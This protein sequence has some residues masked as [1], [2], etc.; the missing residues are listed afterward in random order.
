[1][2]PGS[3]PERGGVDGS[4]SSERLQ[5][6][7]GSD[8]AQL[9]SFAELLPEIVLTVSPTGE[10]AFA[11]S[12]VEET[13]GIEPD[14]F[15]GRSLNL[16]FAKER[17]E[18]IEEL[19]SR[20]DGDE[21]GETIQFAT[22]SGASQPVT[23]SVT[24]LEEGDGYV[25]LASTRAQIQRELEQY[26]QLVEAVGDPMYVLD[27][28]GY[29]QRVNDAMVEYTGYDRTEL[30]GRAIGE[31]IPSREYGR[32]TN[33]LA[34][35][36]A[37]SVQ[38]SET[39][40]TKLVTRDG[41]VIL[42]E[43]N[44]TTLFDDGTVTGSVGVLRDIR[45]RKRR[46]RDLEMLKEV[47]ARV[48]RHNVRNELSV[49][50]GNAEFAHR[51]VGDEL[52][53]YT[54]KI[55]ERTE[56]LL[57]HTEKARLAEEVI[58]TE[59]QYETD[60]AI[61]VEEVKAT[62]SDEYPDATI[63]VDVPDDTS[64]TAIAELDSAIEELL[65]NAIDHAPEDSDAYVT[66]WAD[67]TDEFLTLFVEDESGGLADHEIDVLR[68]GAES[69][70]EHGSGVGLWL[71]RWI[72]EYSNAD[73]IAHRTDNGTLMGIRFPHASN[74]ASES[75]DID[76]SPFTRAPSHVQ[77]IEPERF[78]G[79]IVVGRMDEL[80]ELEDTYAAL[81]RKGGHAVLVTG[82]AGVGKS[83]LVE[84]FRERLVGGEEPPL[85]A[86][87]ASESDVTQPYHVFREA[88]AGL[89]VDTGLQS[90]LEDVADFDAEDPEAVQ[91][92]KQ[93][94]FADMA[95]ELRE[96]ALD[97]S[98]VLVLEDLQWADRGSLDLF[99]YL[100]E[101]V[102]RWAPP[103][104]FVGTCRIDDVGVSHPVLDIA[105]QTAE[106]GRG[107][108]I[109]LDAFEH[110]DVA[111]F[112]EFML[113]I[114]EVPPEFVETVHDHTGGTP[115]FVSELGRHLA[116]TL[117]PSPSA[118]D[119][120]TSLD[121]I[122]APETV[123]SAL[124]ERLD[125]LS[126]DVR[127]VL[128]VGAIVGDTIPFEVLREVS[129][130]PEADLI[131]HVE[132]L[133]GRHIWE[134]DANTLQFV[135]GVLR[136]NIL[137]TVDDDE[138]VALHGE[139]ARTIETLYADSLEEQYGR[140][141]IHYDEA[142]EPETAL[143]YYRRAGDRAA[144]TYAHRTALDHY[145]RALELAEA[146]DSDAYLTVAQRLAEIN[147][148]IGEYDR[149]THFVE[150]VRES[151]DDEAIEQRQQVAHLGA[152]IA[153]ERGEYD[154]AEETVREG[155][156]LDD[157]PSEVRCRL[158]EVLVKLQQEQ[159]QYETAHE[160]AT[161]IRDIATTIG[162]PQLRAVAIHYLGVLGWRLGNV[163]SARKYSTECL[164]IAEE[165]GD[166]K[167]AADSHHFLGVIAWAEGEYDQA[168]EHYEDSLEIKRDISDRHGEAKTLN[169][170][171]LALQDQGEYKQA[172]EYYEQCLDTYRD[173]G[174]RH[175]MA[176]TFN[177]LGIVARIQSE[178]GQAREYYERCL[179]IERAVGGRHGEAKA[180]NNLGE[181]DRQQGVFEQAQTRLTESLEIKREVSDQRDEAETLTHLGYVSYH[182]GEY[183]QAREYFEESLDIATEVGT[184][185]EVIATLCGL[186]AVCRV[187]DDDEGRQF[188]EDGLGHVG[189]GGDPLTV[190]Q[191][192]LEAARWEL[193][194]G[195]LDAAR[196]YTTQ[197]HE[198]FADLGATHWVARSH[199]RHAE[200]AAAA[201][202]PEDAQTYWQAAL[203]AFHTVGAPHD[204][205]AT[206]E[207]LSESYR[208]SGDE[209]RA[210]E[211]REYAKTVC[212]DA[213]DEVTQQHADWVDDHT[214]DE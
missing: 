11:N 136:E 98:V 76:D 57:D 24:R 211:L 118:S 207:Q 21:A 188:I 148:Q 107:R 75:G 119:L 204:T 56:Q 145:E 89:P 140:L 195:N 155:L 49:V 48:F 180:L 40:E 109:E 111:N 106:Y 123:E 47:F 166:Q 164:A 39:F 186:A 52:E 152:M 147:Y 31:I 58:G 99:E 29:L 124:T 70:L 138:Y 44:V 2:S 198:T 27:E 184:T 210:D 110:D 171:G 36:E 17:E 28:D 130:H 51:Q 14:Q 112:V 13:L 135:H 79:E 4:S 59:D 9:R 203:V 3:D 169:N 30:V 159:G 114:G 192:H 162:S 87:G 172:Q 19:L 103:I 128:Q 181:I 150:V 35:L 149:A 116:E 61:T 88:M 10:I 83:T 64:V 33:R 18:S 197:A 157:D 12:A 53:E 174:D 214:S 62:V 153:A 7:A 175:G 121:E 187:T 151:V 54:G 42:T 213:P 113:D 205:L 82:E 108:L 212:A 65:V 139:V 60:L 141:A 68:E 146:A 34:D 142:G 163:D 78:H 102:G 1:M 69:D 131:K 105:D 80:H 178:Y 115:L 120:P 25:C 72:V 90:I 168:R 179:D 176:K 193:R 137:E 160:T 100:I 32:A 86:T 127:A 170:L 73:M 132:T 117:G 95:D 94:L 209:S 38:Q 158:L 156:E 85:L 37:E 199:Q 41:E 63:E 189:E 92:R 45:D 202:A 208:D 77:D 161:E 97:H 133:I 122:E 101:E 15:R 144:E 55:I 183:D 43:A 22:R 81:E 154:T 196:E 74:D 23:L 129:E 67:R 16:L 5:Q 134:R 8:S 96:L 93:A 66:V 182:L 71:I 26:T 165:I 190:A 104:L 177:N 191:L 143:D 200:I 125:A 6:L 206:L 201:G 91:N 84:Q 46:E 20:L 173:L 167:Q 185:D 126:E 50:L 194:D